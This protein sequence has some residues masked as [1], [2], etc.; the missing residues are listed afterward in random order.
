MTT[1]APKINFNIVQ[2]IDGST[3]V[4]FDN[5]TNFLNIQK[6]QANNASILNIL[7]KKIQ[8]GIGNFSNVYS[9]SVD[10]DLAVVKKIRWLS[11]SSISSENYY[12][13]F[14]VGNL[15]KNT[16]YTLPLV[17]GSKGQV[18]STDGK[19][20]LSF[21]EQGSYAPA[22]ATYILQTPNTSLPKAQALNALDDGLMLKGGAGVVSTK[23]KIDY[24][25]LDGLGVAK[26]PVPFSLDFVP[27]P[28]PTFDPTS[29]VDYFLMFNGPWLPQAYITDLAP[30]PLPIT[31]GVTYTN[32]FAMLMIR[33]AKLYTCFKKAAGIVMTSKKV[34]WDWTNPLMYAPE[35]QPFLK[36]YDIDSSFTF[37]KAQALDELK[38]VEPPPEPPADR[39]DMG[40][41]FVDNSTA[42]EEKGII[43]FATLGRDYGNVSTDI[44]ASPTIA[45]N[46]P[47]WIQDKTTQLV[48]T[49]VHI[50]RLEDKEM[51]DIMSGIGTLTAESQITCKKIITGV[52]SISTNFKIEGF[53]LYLYDEDP[54]PDRKGASF[55]NYTG[56]QSEKVLPPDTK[57]LWTLPSKNGEPGQVLGLTDDE[58]STTLTFK[59]S[60]VDNEATFILQKFPDPNTFKHAQALNMLEGGPGI[61]KT[62]ADGVIAIAVKGEDYAT[63]EEV[64]EAVKEAKEAATEAKSAAADAKADAGEASISAAAASTSA[65]IA[66]G[67]ATVAGIASLAAIAAAAAAGVEAAAAAAAAGAAETAAG[68]AG[69]AAT[70]AGVSAGLAAKWASNADTSAQN[71]ETSAQNS[72]TSAQNSKASAIDSELSAQKAA[73]YADGLKNVQYIVA[74]KDTNVPNAQSLGALST[75][76]LKNVV[77]DGVGT[78]SITSFTTGQTVLLGGN[79]NIVTVPTS[80]ITDNS[81]VLLTPINNSTTFNPNTG[82][83]S[84]FNIIENTSF[85]VYSNNEL[86]TSTVNWLIINE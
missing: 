50:E 18:L 9:Q 53:G 74:T 1:C 37:E 8:S 57:I 13:E 86:D 80:A 15:A 79:P 83:L 64:K 24:N 28:N 26:F 39:A 33:V 70:A 44:E 36:T 85:S 35:I 29:A 68:I 31:Q 12:V 23:A 52:E 25:Y 71:S 54:H 11:S 40:L 2:N 38:T 14:Q 84:V 72:E 3:T 60:G 49:T 55:T 7:S 45:G 67:A 82:A 6:V 62:V 5:K 34:N 61:L 58:G 4:T 43:R 78:L 21:I 22:D 41:L 73:S 66:E 69:V 81:T 63:A 48:T 46:V 75:G 47:V 65:G 10:T 51:K 20:V 42:S 59:N 77:N 27:I 32:G 76:L 56:F 30:G 17:D 16:V 19:G